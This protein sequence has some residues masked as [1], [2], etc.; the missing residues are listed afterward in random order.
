MAA[1]S[2]PAWFGGRWGDYSAVTVDPQNTRR[3]WLVNEDILSN[4][5]G[6]PDRRHR[7]RLMRRR[8]AGRH[9]RPSLR[10]AHR[11]P[12]RFADAMISS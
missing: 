9:D 5:L 12:R 4:R 1:F 10:R 3:A 7:L 8:T 11:M 6:Q 2:S